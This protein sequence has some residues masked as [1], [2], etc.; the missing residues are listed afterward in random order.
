MAPGAEPY[1][2]DAFVGC[3]N[4]DHEAYSSAWL[5]WSEANNPTTPSVSSPCD[6]PPDPT[7]YFTV[8]I[9]LDTSLAVVFG[10]ADLNVERHCTLTSDS[11]INVP[12]IGGIP[13]P[14]L[15]CGWFANFAVGIDSSIVGANLNGMLTLG[16][17]SFPPPG[18]IAYTR[19]VGGGGYV[20]YSGEGHITF[21][22]D[23]REGV[24]SFGGGLG[25]AFNPLTGP[26]NAYYVRGA[27]VYLGEAFY[28]EDIPNCAWD[29]VEEAII[30]LLRPENIAE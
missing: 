26:A 17:I 30:N 25:F 10:T 6:S 11:S 8:G 27:S 20:G 22:D 13:K 1:K 4:G 15:K 19:S 24:V 5:A 2:S 23:R 28:F 14:R 21:T 16:F 7:R 29:K 3:I 12:I 9:R 18:T